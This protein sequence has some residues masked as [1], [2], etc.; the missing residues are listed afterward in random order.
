M[1]R[2]PD[3]KLGVAVF[4]NDDDQGSSIMEVI[5]YRI[6]DAALGLPAI[7]WDTRY[8]D[9]VQKAFDDFQSKLVPRPSNPIPPPA[10]YESLA[11][12]YTNGGYGD[13][14]LCLLGSS[15]QSRS[16][17]E[18]ID[19]LP[20]VLP[21][22]AS[23]TIPTLIAKW[24]RFWSTHVK[25][26]HFDGPLFNLTVLESREP[27]TADKDGPYWTAEPFYGQ[28]VGTQFVMGDAEVG[29]V[30]GFGIFGGFWGSGSLVEDSAE[31]GSREAAEVFF[32][33][34]K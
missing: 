11:G 24:D 28:T 30:D 18:V 2:L 19:E 6:I 32:D 15:K 13:I 5:K 16:C 7:D 25:L 29:R 31:G 27:P 14:E 20:T 33:K 17:Q 3:S 8:K 1:I 21:G 4:T 22:V 12:K 10:S 23:S 9:R 34:V 26:E